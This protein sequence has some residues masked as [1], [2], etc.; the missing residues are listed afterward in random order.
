MSADELALLDEKAPE[1]HGVLAEYVKVD[2]VEFSPVVFEP[3]DDPA[4][5][6]FGAS[7]D[8][9]D[10]GTLLLLPT[11]GHSA[12]SMSLL[13]R[14]EGAAPVL[15]VGDVTYN[16]DLLAKGVVPDTGAREVQLQTARKIVA[17]TEALPG[18]AVVAAHDPRVPERL[19]AV[20]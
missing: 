13:V 11:P 12:G 19:A 8:I 20:S 3:N 1:M 18:L 2:G 14:R 10:D 7:F 6:A 4:L 17:L 16:P 5:A 15:L 9:F